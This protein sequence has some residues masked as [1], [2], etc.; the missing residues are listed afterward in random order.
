MPRILV[1]DDNSNV[2]RAVATALKGAGIDVVAVGNGEAAVRKIVEIAPELVLAD[3]FMPVRS[4][5]E[6][7][8]FVKNDSRF[9]H[10]PVVLLVGAF[11]PLDDHEAQRVRAD[12]VL[13][14]PFVPPDPLVNMV[15]ALLAK[16]AS[17]QLVP[18]AA[19]VS[20]A[21]AEIRTANAPVR[22]VHFTTEIDEPANRPGEPP[23]AQADRQLGFGAALQTPAADRPSA[24]EAA[25]TLTAAR[26]PVLGDPAFWSTPADTEDPEQTSLQDMMQGHSW[27]KAERLADEDS[28]DRS[29]SR[30]GQP[31]VEVPEPEDQATEA[32]LEPVSERPEGQ[33]RTD[34]AAFSPLENALPS[35]FAPLATIPALPS[36][37]W[38]A[39]EETPAQ[40]VNAA[41]PF[42]A[43]AVPEAPGR[44]EDWPSDPVS[45]A[46]Q[47]PE[48]PE[49]APEQIER[50][51]SA[52]ERSL[53]MTKAE[54]VPETGG[55]AAEEWLAAPASWE[56]EEREPDPKQ[57]WIESASEH[58]P[59]AEQRSEA[60][61]APISGRLGE[62][63]EV[64]FEAS[65]TTSQQTPVG[66]LSDWLPAGEPVSFPAEI[67]KSSLPEENAPAQP[68]IS[69]PAEA[70]ASTSPADEYPPDVAWTP[71]TVAAPI[72]PGPA[73]A[74]LASPPEPGNF[75]TGDLP[76][77]DLHR[78]A[79][80]PLALSGSEGSSVAAR[81]EELG[82][83]RNELGH[84]LKDKL[85]PEMIDAI[86]TRALARV[87][88]QL[89][90]VVNREVL[91]P[92]V[93]ALIR[94]ELEK[95]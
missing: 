91:R 40:R 37:Q 65:G 75:G 13:K 3:I 47:T 76:V 14:K 58:T 44:T 55:G 2:Q 12:G 49:I 57:Q 18:V 43:E 62:P 42:S 64:D 36:S 94:R 31:L 90:D 19:P 39:E 51:E 83:D 52:F 30:Y 32:S 27:G 21:A 87:Q 24:E 71:S 41:V 48:P 11:D 38:A 4:G 23:R 9:S 61:E 81:I 92:V 73:E 25:T 79:D 80:S 95:P 29:G 54:P 69:S 68:T 86:V 26:D 45:L 67:L 17:E 74:T 85:D 22:A 89:M 5:Y 34:E 59:E 53:A 72:Y 56:A 35:N 28:D 77:S 20:S 84:H 78:E 60:S 10:T 33:E 7:C 66:R 6:V 46:N 63:A 15:K 70:A 16:S 82:V 88:P 8:E 93:E 50:F 1:A